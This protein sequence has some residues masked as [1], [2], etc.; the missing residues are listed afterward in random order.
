MLIYLYE[1]DIGW[2]YSLSVIYF[3]EYNNNKFI[4][5]NN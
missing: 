1:L 5:A 3:A 2:E 4:P